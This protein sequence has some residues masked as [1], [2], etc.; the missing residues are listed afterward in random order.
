MSI[1]EDDPLT[2]VLGLPSE[3]DPAESERIWYRDIQKGDLGY[4]VR[5]NGKTMV[6][7]DR[8]M[9]DLVRP[10]RKNVWQADKEHRPITRHQVAKVAFEADKALCKVLGLHDKA[11]REWQDL[12]EDMRIAWVEKGPEDRLERTRVYRGM[13]AALSPYM[14]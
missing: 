1:N 2:E 6:R 14:K 3:W 13:M 4:L 8:P 9:E 11:R 10:F 12:P 7:L 5:R